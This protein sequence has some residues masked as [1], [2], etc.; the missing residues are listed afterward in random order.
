[1]LVEQ[2]TDSVHYRSGTT[3]VPVYACPL[4]PVYAACWTT[5]EK[6]GQDQRS[7]HHLTYSILT[8]AG[9]AT[10]GLDKEA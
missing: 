1:M 8:N 2:L 6:H 9:P 4:Q 7:V 5:L 10:L 3:L